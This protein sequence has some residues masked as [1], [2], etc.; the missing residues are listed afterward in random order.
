MFLIKATANGNKLPVLQNA[1]YEV[2]N[3]NLTNK[4]KIKKKYNKTLFI[5]KM[6]E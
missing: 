5:I 2:I 6:N 4:I 1:R 3:E